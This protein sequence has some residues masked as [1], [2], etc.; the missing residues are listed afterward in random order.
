MKKVVLFIIGIL[1]I[2]IET[3]FTNYISSFLSVDL[4][5]IYVVFISLYIDKNDSLVISGLLGL[6]GDLVS[7][8][9]VGITALLF[10][11]VS[12]FISSIEKSI[13]KDKKLTICL[14]VFLISI[15]YSIIKAV[16]SSVFF[17]P[18]PLIIALIKAVILIPAVNAII[19]YILYSLFSDTLVKLRDEY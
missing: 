19:A 2:M 12:Y 14:L 15:F 8:G 5:L 3:F 11:A 17:V 13:F 6:F 4:L 1:I 10:L 7:G 9:I 18:T 16:V